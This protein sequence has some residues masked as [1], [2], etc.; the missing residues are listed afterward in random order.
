MVRPRLAAAFAAALGLLLAVPGTAQAKPV[1][2]QTSWLVRSTGAITV[3]P[4][5]SRS[6][7]L[8]VTPA[9][10]TVKSL[11]RVGWK[12][13]D[14][15]T[16]SHL[17]VFTTTSAM[18]LGRT[19]DDGRSCP[20]CDQAASEM[21]AALAADPAVTRVEHGRTGGLDAEGDCYLDRAGDDVWM[22]V[23]APAGTTFWY[24]DA[25]HPWVHGEVV[26]T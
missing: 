3:N 10:L 11:D 23:L 19:I 26:V 7:T 25:Y 15:V 12:D 6:S 9:V 13:R 5:G 17:W 1:P 14:E 24:M 22:R 21:A 18:V 2:G 16:G 8:A 20:L 4:D